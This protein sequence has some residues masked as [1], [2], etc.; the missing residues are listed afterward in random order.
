MVR[1]HPNRNIGL[2][3]DQKERLKA[4]LKKEG[5]GLVGDSSAVKI[6][7]WTKNSFAS[8]TLSPF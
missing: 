8:N 6:C 4:Q 3:E 2:I 5:Y 1:K 7:H